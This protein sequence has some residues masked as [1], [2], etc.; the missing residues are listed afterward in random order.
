[1]YVKGDAESD[2]L[3]ICLYVD[4][5]LVTGSSEGE[6]ADFKHKMMSEFDMTDLSHLSYFLGMELKRTDAGILLH[7]SKYANVCLKKFHMMHCNSAMTPADTGLIL[8]KEGSDEK[9]DAT[10]YRQVVGSLRYL[11]NSRP[12]LVFSVGLISRFMESPR[13]SHMLAA[14]RILR[15][16]K[17]TH[18]FGILFPSKPSDESCAELVGYTDSDWCGDKGDRKSTAGQVFLFGG[19]PVSWGSKKEAVVALSSCQMLEQIFLTSITLTD[20]IHTHTL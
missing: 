4:D 3:I 11:C 17:G 12:D 6:I 19:T 15:Y 9:V 18:D 20:L 13:V 14:K 16:V 2:M 1:M 8:L 5:L 10:H 7:Q